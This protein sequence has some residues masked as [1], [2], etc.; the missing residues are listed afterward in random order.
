M[1]AKKRWYHFYVCPEGMVSHEGFVKA[2]SQE[3][4]ELLSLRALSSKH[5]IDELDHCELWGP[6]P[7]SHCTQDESF[8]DVY[9]YTR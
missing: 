9:W 5:A 8:K 3:K 1:R 4:S 7:M 2:T 6:P